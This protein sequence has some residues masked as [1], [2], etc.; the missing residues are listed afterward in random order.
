MAMQF[1]N[2]PPEADPVLK[3]IPYR[4]GREG[5][6]RTGGDKAMV[7]GSTRSYSDVSNE[8]ANYLTNVPNYQAYCKLIEGGE[9]AEH[10]VETERCERPR[11]L[12][13]ADAIKT[14]SRKLA[15]PRNEVETFVAKRFAAVLGK[16]GQRD[17]ALYE[18]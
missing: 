7:K 8:T 5:V 11:D 4:T 1:D 18:A 16:N 17:G 15:R 10:F 3:S 6:Y 14:R 13:V 2:S 9:L 12:S